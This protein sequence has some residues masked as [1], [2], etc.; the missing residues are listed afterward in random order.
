MAKE[1]LVVVAQPLAVSL[2][3][4]AGMFEWKKNYFR[5]VM[6]RFGIAFLPGT[7]RIATD[8]LRWL[9]DV[10]RKERSDGLDLEGLDDFDKATLKDAG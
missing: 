10:I 5:K 2:E 9:V 4:A 7:E 8:D 1:G 3:T 6:R